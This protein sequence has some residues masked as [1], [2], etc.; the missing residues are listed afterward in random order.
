MNEY[1]LWTP[2]RHQGLILLAGQPDVCPIARSGVLILV[3][4]NKNG[5]ALKM[6]DWNQCPNALVATRL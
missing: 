1:A 4:P 3:P 6:L 2:F 5:Y